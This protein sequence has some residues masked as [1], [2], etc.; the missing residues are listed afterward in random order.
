MVFNCSTG[1]QEEQLSEI[2]NKDKATQAWP[3]ILST[4]VLPSYIEAQW[5]QAL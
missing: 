4:S 5:L 3:P 2:V 1:V